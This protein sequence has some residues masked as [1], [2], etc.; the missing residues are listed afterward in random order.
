MHRH[1]G[2]DRLTG[3]PVDQETKPRIKS[4]LCRDIV[5]YPDRIH[6][7][8][9]FVDVYEPWFRACLRYGLC[10]RDKCI[11]NRDCNVAGLDS[12]SYER[13]AQCIRATA[14]ADA[15]FGATEVRKRFFKLLNHRTANEAGGV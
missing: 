9:T 15:M 8:C 7:V 5:V 1:D 14:N 10:S 12:C 4:A 11:G 2:S 13:E 6:V 3:L